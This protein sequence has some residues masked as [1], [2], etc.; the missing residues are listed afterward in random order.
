M[1]TPRTLVAL[2][3]ALALGLP[4]IAGARD[5]DFT[6]LEGGLSAGFVNDVERPGVITG[7]TAGLAFESD[8]GGGAY[9][10]G[11]WQFAGHLHVFGDYASASQELEVR[12]GATTVEGDYQVV[13]SR[14]GIGY[15]RSTSDTLGF[16]GRL[17]LDSAALEDLEVAGYDL[18]ADLDERGVGGE[19]GV[20]WMASPTIHLQGHLRYTAVGD[21]A[22]DG[23]DGFDADVLVGLAGRWYVRPNVALVT[24]YELGKITTW[25]LGVRYAF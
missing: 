9:I 8:A 20:V 19:L 1:S 15:A 11:A 5:L 7:D 21:V 24:G 25:N 2:S 14:L 13:R 10:S 16:Y 18:A 12:D 6:Y 23:A 17:S 22:A 3:A 4:S